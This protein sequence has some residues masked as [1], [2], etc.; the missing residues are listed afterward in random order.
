VIYFDN[1]A[2]SW[3]KPPGVAAAMQ[4]FLRDGAANPG[5]S[6]HALS[7]EAARIVF[8]TRLR[9]SQLVGLDDP[10]SVVFTKNA[11]EAL[12]L[13]LFALL[14]SG[15][16]VISTVMEHNSVLRP[17]RELEAR[18]VVV[19]RVAADAEGQV[20]PDTLRRTLGPQARLLVMAHAG[21]VTG[22]LAPIAE[23]GAW[24]REQGMLFLVDAAQSAGAV[25]IDME[26]M[27]IDLLALTGHKGLYGPQ[28]T[29]ALCIGERARQ[30]LRPLLFGGTGSVSDSDEQP[31]FLPDALEAGTLNA[32]GIAGLGAALAFI[33]ERGV[34]QIRAHELALCT[35]LMEG[36]EAIPGV[37]VL[38]GRQARGRTAVV[39]FNLEGY[40]CSELA[41]LLEERAGICAR[42]GLHCAPLAH[43]ALG[44]YPEGALRFG[45]SY[46]NTSAEVDLALEV[47]REL[48]RNEERGTRNC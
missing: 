45:L 25:P 13:A 10:L 19:S 21:N 26:A 30:R 7:I 38:G 37:K 33:E 17:L 48:A 2:T 22:G 18:G 14:Q 16:Q 43:R 46:F 3:P 39:S 34:E 31:T 36:L 40:R 44:T 9:L 6:G 23:L 20:D 12:N 35:Q 27:C 1:A 42:A 24:A 47:L 8:D 41:E 5:R 15:D 32:V 29:G 28:G 4:A 11:T